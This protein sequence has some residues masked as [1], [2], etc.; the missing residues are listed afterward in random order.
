MKS[1][2]GY[3]FMEVT[4]MGA[5]SRQK[6]SDIAASS[7]IAAVNEYQNDLKFLATKVSRIGAQLAQIEQSSCRPKK[8]CVQKFPLSSQSVIEL[9]KS[10]IPEEKNLAVGKR[11]LDPR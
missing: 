6:A 7:C 10:M 11:Y 5:V 3:K 1:V 8:Y 2:Q 4:F 9:L